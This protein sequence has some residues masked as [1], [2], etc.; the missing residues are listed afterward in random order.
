MNP[1]D[2]YH[3]FT[4][5]QRSI[6]FHTRTLEVS[7]VSD[8]DPLSDDPFLPTESVYEPEPSPSGFES[9][10]L[11]LTD[12]CNLRCT[13]CFERLLSSED[14]T[15]RMSLPLA[16]KAVD[17][18]LSHIL[19]SDAPIILFGG[20]PM[21]W[22]EDMPSLISY[23]NSLAEEKDKQVRWLISTNGSFIPDEAIGFFQE[24]SVFL[25]INIDGAAENHNACR[26]FA[27]G[28]GSYE[29]ILSNYRKVQEAGITPITLR[30]TILPDNP[31]AF[32]MYRT[33]CKLEPDDIQIYPSYFGEFATRWEGKPLEK[34][35]D[36]YSEIAGYIHSQILKGRFQNLYDYPFSLFLYHLV[37][38]KSKHQYCGGYGKNLVVSPDGVFYPCIALDRQDKYIIGDITTGPDRASLKRWKNLCNMENRSSC[39][40]CWARNLCGGGCI[41]HTVL[42]NGPDGSPAAFECALI[43][44]LIE[45][46]IWLYLEILERN[47]AFFLRF[48]PIYREQIQLLF[49]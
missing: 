38:G 46:S 22:W 5:G 29:T 45:L 21:L 24:H 1:S 28:T 10:C 17:W 2:N 6:R 19:Q 31:D 18:Y 30:G 12:A 27:S 23:G 14:S 41:S 32:Q 48:T 8:S 9:L 43:R 20:E 11:I 40:E 16:K 26:P 35:L 4:R 42:I 37:A 39:R 33:L 7:Y 47:P 44:H 13:Y 3:I 49:I 36:G 34:V 25:M 15:R